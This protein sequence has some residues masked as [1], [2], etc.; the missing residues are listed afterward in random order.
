MNKRSENEIKETTPF[1]IAT[2]R[3][4]IPKETKDLY[5][6]NY[7]TL[8]KEIKNDIN[9]LR[10]IPCSWIGKNNIVKM[11]TYPKQSI[12]LMQ[13]LLNFQWYFSQS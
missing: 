3:I 1:T 5:A 6:E 10:D 9:I 13:S 8:M 12:D 7:M 4:N 11:T 2:K